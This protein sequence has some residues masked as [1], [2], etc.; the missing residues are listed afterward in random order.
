M[1]SNWK[2]AILHFSPRQLLIARIAR[3]KKGNTTAPNPR[4]VFLSDPY[5]NRKWGLSFFIRVIREIRGEKS[6]L[7]GFHG[8]GHG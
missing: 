4:S 7:F 3:I 6:G 5:P 8:R 1:I 2:R